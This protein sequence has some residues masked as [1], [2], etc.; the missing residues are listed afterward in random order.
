VAQLAM[1][2]DRF[3]E[4]F[5]A[6]TAVPGLAV[7]VIDQQGH[8]LA[9]TDKGRVAT[10]EAERTLAVSLVGQPG[11]DGSRPVGWT[12]SRAPDAATELAVVAALRAAPWALSLRQDEALAL[13]PVR[14]LRLGVLAL[15]PALVV[16]GVAFALG[17]ARS[18][19]Q[20]L[21]VLTRAAGRIR[22][23]ELDTAIPRL[24]EDEI[25][26]LGEGL[27]A[28]RLSLKRLIDEVAAANRELEQ[29]VDDRTRELR[30]LYRQLQQRQ[31][32]RGH[33]LQK[34]VTA[35]EDERKRI[36]RELHDET[37][38]TLALLSLKLETALMSRPFDLPQHLRDA[39][40]LTARAID[41]VHQLIF[42]LRPSVLDDLGLGPAIRW[43]AERQLEPLGVNVRC[44]FTGLDERLPPE[45]ETAVFR[46]VQEAVTNIARHAGADAVLVEASLRDGLLTVEIEDDGKGFDPEEVQVSDATGA[47]LGLLGM[48][49]RV[50]VFGG[51]L[52]LESAPRRGTR[53]TFRIPVPEVR[54]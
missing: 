11:L 28:M 17:A 53:V 50:E 45:I 31:A 26:A 27:D 30:D 37:S 10:R 54:P 42:N 6:I 14:W 40:G 3:N 12:L 23:G 35:Q 29:R 25:G 51:S 34:L 32:S 9:S 41:E 21:A 8:L 7:D 2:G 47:G 38:Q 4:L 19:R 36:A 1:R 43:V 33:L 46:V 48:R 39:Q 44:E 52:R 15:A 20:P 5:A 22:D 13:K 18:V 49:E 16:I 24:G